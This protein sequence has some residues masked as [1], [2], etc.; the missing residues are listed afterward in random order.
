MLLWDG[1]CLCLGP[2]CVCLSSHILTGVIF[3]FDKKLHR[4]NEKRDWIEK[5][6]IGNLWC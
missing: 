4:K 5:R 2:G 6:V 3:T 1:L